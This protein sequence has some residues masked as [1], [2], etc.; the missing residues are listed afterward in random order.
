[1]APTL[2]QLAGVSVPERFQGSDL[3][4]VWT[5]E[6]AQSRVVLSELPWARVFIVDGFK[7][8]TRGSLFDL[9]VDPTEQN[10]VSATMPERLAQLIEIDEAWNTELA[11]AEQYVRQPTEVRLT[12]EEVRRLRALGY[13]R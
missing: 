9:R 11:R 6:Q 2:L 3:A 5:G 7:F 13:L 12:P 10:D 8:D 4:P 1:M